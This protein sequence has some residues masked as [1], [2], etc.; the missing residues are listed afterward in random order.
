[1]QA[2]FATCPWK[3]FGE[4]PASDGAPISAQGFNEGKGKPFTN[5][6]VRYTVSKDGRTLYAIVMGWPQGSMTLKS[7]GTDAGLLKQ[8]VLKVRL[9]GSG[10]SISWELNASA[11]VLENVPEAP[12][13]EARNAAVFEISLSE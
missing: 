4:G 3:V 10:A 9:L 12:E 8:K 13:S 1:K 2:I 5:Q 6:D 7:L 11:L